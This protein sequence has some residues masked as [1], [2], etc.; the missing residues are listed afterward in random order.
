MMIF[1]FGYCFRF[2]TLIEI[3]LLLMTAVAEMRRVPAFV[4]ERVARPHRR[5]QYRNRPAARNSLQPHD[6]GFA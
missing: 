2:R 1:C 6:L 5:R 3:E 4:K